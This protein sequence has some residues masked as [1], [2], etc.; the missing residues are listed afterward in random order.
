MGGSRQQQQ[1]CCTGRFSGA[2]QPQPSNCPTACSRAAASCAGSKSCRCCNLSTCGHSCHIDRLC[3]HSLRS[4][5]P[6]WGACPAPNKPTLL[7][8]V[9]LLPPPAM[10]CAA[11]TANTLPCVATPRTQVRHPYR[12]P[13]RTASRRCTARR[14]AGE[15][16]QAQRQPDAGRHLRGG[17][18]HARPQLRRRLLG[19]RQGDAGHLRVG[20]APASSFL[21]A[22]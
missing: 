8:H 11:N 5:R 2:Q 13:C 9:F 19:N 15:E 18:H 3:A 21:A 7:A 10:P 16:H 1:P 17:A 22:S 4:V 12:Q 20:C 6:C 14:T